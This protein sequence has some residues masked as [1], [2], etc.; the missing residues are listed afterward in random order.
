MYAF[1][2]PLSPCILFLASLDSM[3]FYNNILHFSVSSFSSKIAFT[4]L[5]TNARGATSSVP[6]LS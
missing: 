3:F 4:H 1:S 2:H 5:Q 6:F